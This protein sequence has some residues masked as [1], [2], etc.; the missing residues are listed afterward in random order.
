MDSQKDTKVKCL[1]TNDIHT[2]TWGICEVNYDMIWLDGMLVYDNGKWA[3]IKSILIDI[4]KEHEYFFTGNFTKDEHANRS[5]YMKI[6]FKK[7]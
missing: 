6:Y 4:P 7:K 1:E 2:I 5:G 3:E